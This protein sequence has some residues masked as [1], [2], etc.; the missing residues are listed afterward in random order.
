MLATFFPMTTTTTTYH[1]LA[2][3]HG[4]RRSFRA[5]LLRI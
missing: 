2:S 5:E 4:I 1:Y 3:A